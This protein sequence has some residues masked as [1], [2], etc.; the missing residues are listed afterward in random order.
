[1]KVL[2]TGG[3]GF[4][5]T[6]LSIR[7][8]E[9]GHLVTVVDRNPEPGPY[10]PQEVKYISADTTIR[11][12]WQE[13]VARQEAVIN[14]AKNLNRSA[15]LAVSAAKALLNSEAALNHVATA[16][17]QLFKSDDA[18]EGIVAFLEKR[19]PAFKGS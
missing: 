18:Q 13:E 8:L 4:V 6:Q 16:Q 12:A 5:G 19:K 1:M 15:P 7:L 2:I 11:G 17:V 14:L 10:T 3:L 9:R